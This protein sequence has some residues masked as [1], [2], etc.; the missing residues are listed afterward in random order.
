[1][2]KKQL[3]VG[4]IGTGWMGRA[5]ANAFRTMRYMGWY[6]QNFEPVLKIV[7][8]SSLEKGA[9][10]MNRFGFERS[11]AGWEEIVSASDV[12]VVDNVT[13]DR[14]HMEPSIAAAKNGKHIFCE[15]PLAVSAAD[16]KRML[17]AVNEA[18]VKSGCGFTYRFFPAV[19]LAHDLIKEGRLGKIYHFSGKYFQDQ[20][21][22]EDAPAEDVWYIN[23]S[24]IGQGITSHLI[25]M[26]RFLVGEPVSVQGMTSTYNTKRPSKKGGTVTCTADEGFFAMI[27]FDNGASGLYESLGVANGKRNQFSWEIYGSKGSMMW[28]LSEP[29]Y[30][31]LF[32]DDV[33]DPRVKGFTKINVTE[34]VH[35][36]LKMWWPQGHVLGWEHGHI[37][38]LAHFLDCIANDRPVA[39]LGGTFEDGYMV[40]KIIEAIN[41]SSLTGQRIYL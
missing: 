10:A 32:L 20:G 14:L 40:A 22:H 8:G 28:D 39:P 19:R 23:W 35:P 3:R 9:D 34:G 37:N 33:C 41:A 30:L 36:L 11:C 2:D 7:G 15:K 18:G 1:M 4:M 21:S 5:H 38:M 25:D 29:N 27:G 31:H 16:A 24:G 12:D 26:S 6:D 13:P 17:D